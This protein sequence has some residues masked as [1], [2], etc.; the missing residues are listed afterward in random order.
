MWKN[1]LQPGRPEMTIK[2]DH[3]LF[4]LDNSGCRHTH[5][6]TE[7]I[8]L[9]AFPRQQWLRER[10]SMSRHTY[11]TSYVTKQLGERRKSAGCWQQDTVR[12]AL[13]ACT[14]VQTLSGLWHSVSLSVYSTVTDDNSEGRNS[15]CVP[16][17]PPGPPKNR[18]M[19]VRLVHLVPLL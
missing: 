11:I 5:T 13:C 15:A 16:A 18:K 4:T 12:S 8:I 14:P 10:V 6:H 17:L 7:Y 9:I 19:S 3:A 1:I 2:K